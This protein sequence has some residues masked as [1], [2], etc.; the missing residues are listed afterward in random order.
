MAKLV[1][2]QVTTVYQKLYY[3]LGI[4]HKSDEPNIGL[5]E[6]R[7]LPSPAVYFDDPPQESSQYQLQYSDDPNQEILQPQKYISPVNGKTCTL[8]VQST[9]LG[10][11]LQPAGNWLR[12]NVSG[13]AD[14][15]FRL[16][17][18]TTGQGHHYAKPAYRSLAWLAA[19]MKAA[20][21][22]PLYTFIIY[23]Y[24]NANGSNQ[25]PRI[26]TSNLPRPIPHE[27][28]KFL[29][30]C[31]EDPKHA[32]SN[33]DVSPASFDTRSDNEDNESVSIYTAIEQ[34]RL[35]RP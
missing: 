1:T 32:P 2:N 15:I 20:L 17:A 33:L 25:A 29:G 31:R 23:R 12:V 7:G 5:Q 16:A 24:V 14:P 6:S 35:Y 34:K 9:S 10:G 18:W 4:S 28:P 30:R 19:L 22:S 11:A 13:H 8:K 21:L 26:A 3:L 27:Y